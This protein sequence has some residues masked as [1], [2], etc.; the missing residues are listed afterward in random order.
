MRNSTTHPLAIDSVPAAAG[1]GRIGL[2]SC[3][4]RYDPGA[5][6]GGWARD[7]AADLDAIRAWGAAAVATLVEEEELAL[8]RVETLGRDVEAR[9]MAW[10]HLPIADMAVPGASF[11]RGWEAAG[12]RLRVLL[13]AGRDIVLHCRGG[14]GRSGTIGARLLVEF[15]AAPA[16]AI[17][18]I[19][20]ARP[21]AIET[22]EQARY[23]LALAPAQP[24]PVS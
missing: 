22:E 24:R 9:G 5:S 13:A 21:G 2:V 11:E 7:L 20:V 15:G 8:L 17:R 1:A 3:P 18:A 19:R 23:V 12:P 10:F 16:E 4:G 14:L 6:G